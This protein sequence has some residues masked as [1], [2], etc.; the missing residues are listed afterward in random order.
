MTRRGRMRINLTRFIERGPSFRLEHFGASVTA[1]THSPFGG[2]ANPAANVV[3]FIGATA[4]FVS[5]SRSMRSSAEASR[6]VT[7]RSLLLREMAKVAANETVR[8]RA[9]PKPRRRYSM[10][11]S[12]Y[13]AEEGREERSAPA[14]IAEIH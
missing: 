5:A 7:Y 3:V 6:D 9:I 4:R 2:A 10:D 11:Q 13:S 12:E 14:R 1:S 8:Q